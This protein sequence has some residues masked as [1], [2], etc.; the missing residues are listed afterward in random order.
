MPHYD[1]IDGRLSMKEKMQVM[2][3]TC[4]T[5]KNRFYKEIGPLCNLCKDFSNYQ[6]PSIFEQLK[7]ENK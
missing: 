5:C 3:F 4:E 7:E 2:G 1:N 6:P